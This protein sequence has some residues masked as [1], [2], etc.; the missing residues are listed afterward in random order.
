MINFI[1]CDTDL[2]TIKLVFE[3]IAKYK[4]ININII[5]SELEELYS[6]SLFPV[7]NY[8][9]VNSEVFT[10][11]E[12]LEIPF[13]NSKTLFFYTKDDLD[14]ITFFEKIINSIES[15]DLEHHISD[16]FVKHLK[17]LNFD[18][19]LS[20]THYLIDFLKFFYLDFEEDLSCL[21]Y[22]FP[23]I[24]FQKNTIPSKIF[25]NTIIAIED[26]YLKNGNITEIARFSKIATQDIEN[27]YKALYVFY[28]F[29]KSIEPKNFNP[30]KI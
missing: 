9:L 30:F 17:S 19:S 11:E 12:V 1:L 22:I 28:D 27:D 13:I 25:Y 3:S 6:C 5:A 24:A 4:K 8:Y 16:F 7:L 2:S 15:Q 21:K 10:E 18:F 20:G 14:D 26:M 29:I 23:Y